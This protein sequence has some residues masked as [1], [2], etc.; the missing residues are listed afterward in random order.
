MPMYSLATRKLIEQ[1]RDAAPDTVQ[2]WFAG[3]S[4]DAGKISSIH[5]WWEKL[6]ELGPAYGY[7]P[8]AAKTWLI[9]KSPD[10]QDRAEELF[11]PD[12]VNITC[13]GKR[14]IG[15]VIGTEEF[16]EAFVKK[17]SPEVD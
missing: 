17:K 4:A 7:Y 10:L 13:E 5:T 15:A 9:L 12:G 16:K 1:L 2:V 14:H 6:K 11:G 3:D 8:N